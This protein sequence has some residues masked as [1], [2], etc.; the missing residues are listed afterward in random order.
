MAADRGVRS[1]ALADLVTLV[2][3]YL[4]ARATQAFE[5][6]FR[7]YIAE[8]CR[9]AVRAGADSERAVCVPEEDPMEAVNDVTERT[10][11]IAP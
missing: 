5:Y 10:R 6:R 11:R 9:A 3:M 8:V 1:E 7:E 4:P 2:G